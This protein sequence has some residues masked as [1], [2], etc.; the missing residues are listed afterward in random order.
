DTASEEYVKL[1]YRYPENELVAET[2]ARLGQYF[3][4]RGKDL[5]RQAQQL[6]AEAESLDGKEMEDKKVESEK[7]R[8]DSL[9]TYKTAGQVFGRLAVRFPNHNLS[10]KTNVLSGQ[11]FIMAE[12]L[13]RATAILRKTFETPEIDKEIAATAMYW[14]AHAYTLQESSDGYLHAYRIFKR[15][16]WDY[17]ASKWAKY[18]RG[19]LTEDQFATM[20]DE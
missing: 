7:S 8:L 9:K 5:K 12:Q 1:S 6:A 4:K 14:C 16:T 18:A 2:I 19:R 15:L 3:M 11:A 13:E 20:E 17:P 10:G